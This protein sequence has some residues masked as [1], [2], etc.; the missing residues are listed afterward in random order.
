MSKESDGGGFGN[1]KTEKKGVGY[2]VSDNGLCCLGLNV[3][4]VCRNFPTHVT[5]CFFNQV[6]ASSYALLISF[7][8]NLFMDACIYLSMHS[9]IK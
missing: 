5:I 1:A 6:I 7:F 9:Y 8:I 4:T 3:V 2:E